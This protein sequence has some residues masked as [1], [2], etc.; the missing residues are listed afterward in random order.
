MSEDIS[1]DLVGI[2]TMSGMNSSMMFL[3]VF[4]AEEDC[5]VMKRN[6][7]IIFW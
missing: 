1:L 2:K 3:S 6:L 4:M 7:R 5:R